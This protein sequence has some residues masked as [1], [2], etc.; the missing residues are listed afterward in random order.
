[1]ISPFALY[2]YAAYGPSLNVLHRSPWTSW[3]T[4]FLLPHFSYT[5]S[6][7]LNALPELGGPAYRRRRG[8]LRR[9]LRPGVQHEGQRPGARHRR[10]I[11]GRP[12]PA[13]PRARPRRTGHF[14]P[15]APCPCTGRLRDDDVPLRSPGQLGRR[16]RRLA[17]FGEAYRAYQR[18]TGM[19]LPRPL[20]RLIPWPPAGRRRGLA[21]LVLW[22]IVVAATVAV[23]YHVRDDALRSLSAFYTDD[24]A[25]LSPAR[26]PAAPLRAAVHLAT[27][28]AEARERI[29]P[30]RQGGKLLVYVLP[31][32]WEDPRPPARPPV[33]RGPHP[34]RPWALRPCRLRPGSLPRA[35][36]T[37]CGV[38]ILTPAARRSSS[39]LT[40]ASRSS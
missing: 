5:S 3:L 23:G 36:H 12:P 39:G 4:D 19:F 40:G 9:R 8:A 20:P 38:T 30:A 18:R 25:V 32:A 27:S 34:D 1:M 28:G 11:P 16:T 14:P 2:Y 13:I 35:F 7:L 17:K 21:A 29:G 31:E 24:M 6:P 22:F 10:T 26:L 15:L 37:G 33:N